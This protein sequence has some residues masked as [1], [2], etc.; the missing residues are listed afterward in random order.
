MYHK[1][2]PLDQDDLLKINMEPQSE[3]N[4]LNK[5]KMRIRECSGAIITV[6]SIARE[7]TL[8][9]N[10][11]YKSTKCYNNEFSKS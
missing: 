5:K 8:P 9:F 11:D 4:K 7:L 1:R 3:L 2:N 6:G 10:I